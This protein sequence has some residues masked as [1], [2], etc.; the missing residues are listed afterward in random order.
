MAAFQ[1]PFQIFQ[2]IDI[3]IIQ[4][5]GSSTK[6]SVF[7]GK[8]KS[9]G[10]AVAIKN[11]T[12]V[13]L[14]QQ[15]LDDL[16]R[17]QHDHVVRLLG[18]ID[19]GSGVP[20]ELVLEYA[21]NGNL[22]EFLNTATE[23]LPRYLTWCKQAVCAVRYIHQQNVAHRNIKSKKY[24]VFGDVIKLA[25]VGLS[26]KTNDFT[27]ERIT[28]NLGSAVSWMSPEV[29]DE[30][31][32][33]DH[34]KS[35]IYSLGI[36]LWELHYRK[37]PYDKWK[38]KDIIK[39][40]I[41]CKGHPEIDNG[42]D[43]HELLLSCWKYEPN[44]RPTAEEILTSLGKNKGT[45]II[46]NSKIPHVPNPN[47]SLPIRSLPPV[48]PP[49]I[50]PTGATVL[51]ANP[52]PELSVEDFNQVLLDVASWW[53]KHGDVN[54]LKLLLCDFKEIT[55]GNIQH[56]NEPRELLKLLEGPGH[57]SRS[58]IDV[59]VEA[60]NLGGLQGV[61]KLI[62]DKLGPKKFPGFRKIIN[63][64]FS[65]YRRNLVKFGQ[66]LTNK[67]KAKIGDLYS[68]RPEQFEDQWV[69]IFELERAGIL[70][71][72]SKDSFIIK[73]KQNEMTSEANIFVDKSDLQK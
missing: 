65:I 53:E 17:L 48:Q 59:L 69:L 20:T 72:E 31:D 35:D 8:V 56:K 29:M 39:H 55:V 28:S 4:H 60:I 25:D 3:E 49:G 47:T 64:I 38:L 73:L 63:P 57:I 52:Y 36:V 12:N 34:F 43:I 11:I 6:L 45:A 41:N 61:E 42:C 40:V 27:S 32:N 70:T 62:K 14:R 22:Y 15:E 16:K 46:Q 18:T 21:P 9:T 13:G 71:E 66:I 54:L 1:N 33:V 50:P 10:L 2:P 30:N 24:L 7:Q 5:C 68:F 58:N 37:K 19:P 51:P 44:Q 67:N 26:K 23:S